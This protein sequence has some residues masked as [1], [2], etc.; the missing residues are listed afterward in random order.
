MNTMFTMNA[1]DVRKAWSAV[2]DSVIHEKPRF[3]KRLRDTRMLADIRLVEA[4]LEPYRCRATRY[5]EDNG[6]VTLTLDEMDLAENGANDEEAIANLY[7]S[8][9]KTRHLSGLFARWTA[10][11][12]VSVAA[13]I[14]RRRRIP[15]DR[16]PPVP[17]HRT[18]ILAHMLVF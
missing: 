18:N 17:C 8:P 16:F 10:S 11:P 12:S 14:S 7:Q 13:G 1:T 9:I 15:K 2:C 5:I 6:S 4:I 3:I